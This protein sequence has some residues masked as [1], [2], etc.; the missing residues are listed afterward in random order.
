MTS[1]KSISATDFKAKCLEILDHV[2]PE[3]LSVTKRGKKVATIYPENS[4]IKKFIGSIPDL[5]ISGDI[6]STGVEGD[7]ES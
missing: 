4:G 6:Y 1:M 2:P 5:Y 7:A 3:G